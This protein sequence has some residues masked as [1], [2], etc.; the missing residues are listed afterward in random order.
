MKQKEVF[1]KIGGIIQ[2]L[3]DQYEYLRTVPDDLNDL[4]LE[5]FVAN[6]HFLTD[7]IEVLCKLNLQ[8]KPKRTVEKP[9]KPEKP[10]KAE[11]AYEQKYFEPVVQQM[12]HGLD[13][14]E[15]KNGKEALKGDE[16]KDVPQEKVTEKLKK[17]PAKTAESETTVSKQPEKYE[18]PEIDLSSAAP[19][20]TYSFIREEP[21]TIRH[22]LILDESMDRD[23]DEK[24]ETEREPVRETKKT[25]LISP[26]TAETAEE[27]AVTEIINKKPSESKPETVKDSQAAEDEVLTINQKMSSQVND[28]GI[29]HTEQL[30]IKPISDIKLAITLND[31]LLYVK[32]LF[33]GYN[34]AYS[35]A[36]EILNRFNTFE[37]AARFLKTNY[38]TKNNWESKPATTEKFYALLKRRY[39]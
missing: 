1:K 2:E 17:E 13:K 25:R 38:V 6:A 3:S 20:D 4:E 11:I 10:E 9:E 28:K 24:L 8:N 16:P 26:L 21:A 30:T 35:E 32:D 22:E 36:I 15:E 14:E 37:E 19:A 29:A 33:N 7:H 39:A 31:K 27:E 5:L 18:A 34:L 12:K 23:E